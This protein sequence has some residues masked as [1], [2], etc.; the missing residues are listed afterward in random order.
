MATDGLTANLGTEKVKT[1]DV[2]RIAINLAA[3]QG[4][5]EREHKSMDFDYVERLMWA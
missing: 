3:G 4:R 5:G 1:N 2:F